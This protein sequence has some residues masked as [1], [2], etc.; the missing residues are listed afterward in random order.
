MGVDMKNI[1]KITAIVLVMAMLF[2]FAACEK[3]EKKPNASAGTEQQQ[4]YTKLGYELVKEMYG[5]LEYKVQ[6]SDKCYLMEN[7]EPQ[8]YGL[9][10][11]DPSYTNIV[12]RVL[13]VW[14]IQGTIPM[15]TVV[16]IDKDNN[17]DY[18]TYLYD[19]TAKAA[20][21]EVAKQVSTYDVMYDKVYEFQ[22]NEYLEMNDT[23]IPKTDEE[24]AG[25]T[26]LDISHLL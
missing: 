20:A 23:Y 17:A 26:Q 7:K 18:F 16:F 1:K 10:G 5:D 19:E 2:S 24:L 21:E 14:V 22:Y 12:A 15:Y 11:R 9:E 6:F 3:R 4:A 8:D 13:Y 25:W